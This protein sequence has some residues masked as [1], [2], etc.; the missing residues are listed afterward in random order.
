[1]APS[2]PSVSC[3]FPFEIKVKVLNS[4]SVEKLDLIHYAWAM[5]AATI[6]S[7]LIKIGIVEDHKE[8]NSA[9]D[10]LSWWI[11]SFEASE[12]GRD[13]VVK[14]FRGCFTPFN[15]STALECLEPGYGGGDLL[16]S[17]RL[18]KEMAAEFIAAHERKALDQLLDRHSQ[19]PL[20]RTSSRI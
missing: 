1:M 5:R 12:P 16:E 15:L 9:F 2:N 6:A 18:V 3:A 20:N 14:I 13:L 17:N 8:A 7:W 19:L 4:Q 11:N 10:E